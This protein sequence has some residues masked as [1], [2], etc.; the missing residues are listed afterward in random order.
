[1]IEV[2]SAIAESVD[3]LTKNIS[4]ELTPTRHW[5]IL[6]AVASRPRCTFARPGQAELQKDTPCLI[7]K[8]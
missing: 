1:M 6:S 8:G 2:G 5:A 3:R 7:V 4:C